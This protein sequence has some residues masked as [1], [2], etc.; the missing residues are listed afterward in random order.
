MYNTVPY[1]MYKKD[2]FW[3]NLRL[4]RPENVRWNKRKTVLGFTQIHNRVLSQCSA[5]ELNVTK[6]PRPDDAKNT[7]LF[8]PLMTYK[9]KSLVGLLRH[10]TKI[11]QS[12]D[13]VLHFTKQ[14]KRLGVDLTFVQ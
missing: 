2:S 5:A 7:K 13:V 3:L 9:L 1:N 6:Q 10:I 12:Q 14:N 4:L 11:S 8:I